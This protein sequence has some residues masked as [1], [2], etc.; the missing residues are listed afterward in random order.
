MEEIKTIL[1]EIYELECQD[2][3]LTLIFQVFR[4]IRTQK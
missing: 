2:K 4:T 1:T 3:L